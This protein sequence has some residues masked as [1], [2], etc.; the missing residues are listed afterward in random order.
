MPVARRGK[1][2]VIWHGDYCTT[3]GP[4]FSAID[5]SDSLSVD[6]SELF[7]VGFVV[8]KWSVYAM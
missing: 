6:P 2:V 8:L 4:Y 7:H 1:A 3:G 5:H